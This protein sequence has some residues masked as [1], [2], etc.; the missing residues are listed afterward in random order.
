MFFKRIESEGLAHYSYMVGEGG[1]V[2]VIDPRRDISIYLDEARR[3]GGKI[4]GVFE[5]HRNEDCIAGSQELSQFTGADIYLSGHE[6]VGHVYGS[7]IYDGFTM[8]VGSLT[9]KALH[10]PGHTLGHMSYALYEEDR[11][12]P[13]MV[14]SGDSLFLG[15]LARTDF[16]GENQLEKMTG[17]LYDSIFQKILSLGD[18]VLLMPAHGAGSACGASMEDRPYSTLGYERKYN[19]QLQ[20]DSKQAFIKR[21]G[22]MRVRP[23]HFDMIQTYNTKGAKPL[24]LGIHIP[25]LTMEQVMNQNL[26]MVDCRSKEAFLGGHIKGSIYLNPETLSSFLGTMFDADTPIAF[27]MDPGAMYQLED[28][29]LQSRR[30]GFEQIQGFVPD[31]PREWVV[32]GKELET[33]ASI[34]SKA[35]MELKLEHTLLDIRKDHELEEGDPKEYRLHIALEELKQRISEVPKGKPVYIMCASWNRAITAASLLKQHGYNGVV[36]TG[37]VT[38]IRAL[39][40]E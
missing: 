18:D 28:L 12:T 27:L 29:Y 8:E 3:A 24:G 37:G 9:L 17:L 22:R 39:E 30:I 38:G 33:M 16:Y 26:A 2:A 13:Y 21:Y 5:T 31:A 36:I 40:D 35:Y 14:F 7:K 11:E 1:E 6:D 32:A 25:Y 23:A 19:G 4:I 34:D 10:T 20:D 15:D